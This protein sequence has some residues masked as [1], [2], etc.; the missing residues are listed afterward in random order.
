MDK[1]EKLLP[2]LINNTLSEKESKS[3]E[4][5]IQREKC[6]QENLRLTKWVSQVVQTQEV[7][8][9]SQQIKT[10]LLTDIQE[11]S[12]QS[13]SKIQP[14]FW[15][16]P[17]MLLVFLLLWLIV[18]PGTQLQW[19]TTGTAN[20]AFR[21][22]RAPLGTTDFVMLDEFQAEPAQK[23]YQY[24]DL[25]V[26]PGR[27]YQYIIEIQNAGGHNSYGRTVVSNSLM[28]L[29]VQIVILSTSFVLTFGMITIVQEVKSPPRL[30]FSSS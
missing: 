4:D 14:W 15:G 10:R 13:K 24:K 29:V 2:W 8:A 16:A 1:K 20:S 17:V 25:T 22:Y 27:N 11:Q 23:T 26:L 18:R 12:N 21:I 7:Q 9:P 3:V 28:T 19:T 6:N 5:W 30:D